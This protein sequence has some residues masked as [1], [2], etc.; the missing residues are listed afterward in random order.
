ME[1]KF[2]FFDKVYIIHDTTKVDRSALVD[3][4]IYKLNITN[5]EIIEPNYSFADG[6]ESCTDSHIRIIQ[7]A[8]DNN[9]ANIF[10]FEDD[11]V[12]NQTNEIIEVDLEQHLDTC[13][14]FMS[15]NEYSLFYFDNTRFQIYNI[16]HLLVKIDRFPIK[17]ILK[18]FNKSY[19]HSYAINSKVFNAILLDYKETKHNINI[20]LRRVQHIYNDS[21]MYSNGIFDQKLNL[22]SDTVGKVTE[23]QNV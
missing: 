18:C 2:N 1:N 21:Y 13:F 3:D 12:L 19:T 17:N 5:Y 10:I 22:P 23:L 6:G 15:H 20:L 7:D 16:E 4:L 11:V 8:V 14:N 9:Y